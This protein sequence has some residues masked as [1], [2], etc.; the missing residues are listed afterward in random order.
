MTEDNGAGSII[1]GLITQEHQKKEK[2]FENVVHGVSE[3]WKQS[4]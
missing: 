2:H 1:I 3:I 4:I